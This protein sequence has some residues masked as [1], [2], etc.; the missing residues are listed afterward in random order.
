MFE[1]YACEFLIVTMSLTNAEVW[2]LISSGCGGEHSGSPM[3]SSPGHALGL[4]VSK[5]AINDTQSLVDIGSQKG[6]QLGSVDTLL[7]GMADFSA[8]FV[9]EAHSLGAKVHN[10]LNKLGCKMLLSVSLHGLS[11]VGK[12]HRR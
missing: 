7:S 12:P 3:T 2:E 11:P 9:E 4:D 10:E 1:R 6:S 5:W 8:A